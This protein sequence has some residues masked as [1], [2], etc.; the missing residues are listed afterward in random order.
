MTPEEFE[1]LLDRKLDPM[2]EAFDRRFDRIEGRLFFGQ[3]GVPSL[4]EEI[5]A[6]KSAPKHEGPGVLIKQIGAIVLAVVTTAGTMWGVAKAAPVRHQD[7][8]VE[9]NG[10]G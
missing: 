1:D 7:P 2:Q 6:L 8:S 3:P 4:T 10:P 9:R 5:A